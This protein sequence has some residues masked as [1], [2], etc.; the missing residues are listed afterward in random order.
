MRGLSDLNRG[1]FAT[2]L[3][4][5]KGISVAEPIYVYPHPYSRIV[6]QSLHVFDG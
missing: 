2:D 3:R 6:Q 5:G 4:K 1:I